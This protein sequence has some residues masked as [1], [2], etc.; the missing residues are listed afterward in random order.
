MELAVV[1]LGVRFCLRLSRSGDQARSGPTGAQVA[2][3][4]K[5][6]FLQHRFLL[7]GAGVVAEVGYL[8]YFEIFRLPFYFCRLAEKQLQ[9]ALKMV[10]LELF[11]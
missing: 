10:F 2:S 4:P 8:L 5:I 11:C 9:T 1:G 3:S 7:A 6:L